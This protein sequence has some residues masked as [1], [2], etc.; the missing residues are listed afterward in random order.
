M[1]RWW[2]T[3]LPICVVLVDTIP[4]CDVVTWLA[5]CT[6][7]QLIQRQC[8]NLIKKIGSGK[9]TPCKVRNAQIINVQMLHHNNFGNSH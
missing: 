7:N 5:I 9:C 4:E 2:E 1:I 8:A 6:N 3:D